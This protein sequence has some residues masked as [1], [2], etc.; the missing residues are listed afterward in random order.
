MNAKAHFILTLSHFVALVE[1]R[2]LSIA[3][4]FEKKRSKSDVFDAP[5]IT[6]NMIK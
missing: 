2:G 3:T 1:S 6:K 4:L 5:L